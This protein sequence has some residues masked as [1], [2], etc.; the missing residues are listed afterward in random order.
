MADVATDAL[1]TLTPDSIK[2]R[3]LLAELM[4]KQGMD[5][6]PVQSP[7]Q[8]AARMA[9][10]LMG[11]LVE[12]QTDQME[13]AGLKAANKQFSDAIGGSLGAS[14]A[15][16]P[17]PSAEAQPPSRALPAFASDVTGGIN[18]ATAKYGLD[19]TYLPTTAAI[20]SKGN[21][22]ASNP[23]S[24]A[25]GLFQFITSTGR[26]YGLTNPFDPAASADAAARLA[27]DNKKALVA[28]LGREPTPAE[29][30]LAHQQGG[31]GAAR[32]LANPSA[33]AAS[34]V[35]ADAVR[36]NG[37]TPGM[38]A[39]D[40]ANK[41]LSKFNSAAGAP[42][43]SAPAA[44]FAAQ[45][46]PTP[47]EAATQPSQPAPN[48]TADAGNP[49]PPQIAAGVQKAA[50]DPRVMQAAQA[51]AQTPQGQA[52]VQ[53][54]QG[55][56]AAGIVAALSNPWL[57]DGQKSVLLM[58]LKDKMGSQYG[59]Q[60]AGDTLYRTNNRSGTA[61]A[62]QNVGKPEVKQGA[63]GSWYEYDPRARG[64][65]D[66]TPDGA[67][68]GSRPM[69][70]E[71][72]AAYRV[73]KDLP[74]FID[75]KTKT[76]H[77][78]AP[79]VRVDMSPGSG[80]QVFKE[81][82][83]RAG[84]A[85]AAAESLPAFQ[86]A[87]RLVGS[88]NIVLGAGAD[89]RVAMQK[90]GALFGLDASAASNSETFRAAIAPTVLSMVKGLGAG[91]GISNADREFAEKAAGGN[92]TLEPPTIKRLLD[93]G[94]KAARARVDA[95]NKMIDEVYPEGDDTRQVRSLFRVTPRPYTPPEPEAPQ[96]APV[97]KTVNGKDYEQRNGQWY[98]VK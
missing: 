11:G 28:A 72:R 98:E 23:N 45:P 87:R 27:L 94:E 74:A 81:V 1:P 66:I 25:K 46:A 29:L 82:S 60:V 17:A 78:G 9:N 6:S 90:V 16:A 92:I 68:G 31:G 62:V 61:E 3:R 96:A 33:P 91:S 18:A 2:R 71:E 24:S 10:A 26:Q 51:T 42:A 97:R 38:T 93:I 20:E 21:P 41:W 88:G 32:L 86:E 89:T 7:W 69:T 13:A 15:P 14:P 37:G 95:H 83:D 40:F 4:M 76:P 22:N 80:Q 70:D 63:D 85:R 57:N 55:M 43:Q 52:L 8:G 47:A 50:A 49:I 30:Y 67:R 64:M 59:F 58:V 5:Y 79:G 35:G 12:G 19:P 39:G 53:Q 36:L 77:F 54:T 56:N 73:P 44:A 65:R 34:I 84:E 75:L 48:P